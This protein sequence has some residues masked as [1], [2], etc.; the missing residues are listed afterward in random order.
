MRGV[1]LTS[2]PYP[3][4]RAG[5]GR[6]RALARP[7][8]LESQR[9]AG[10]NSLGEDETVLILCS[11]PPLCSY[12]HSTPAKTPGSPK[13]WLELAGMSWGGSALGCGF[14]LTR[15]GSRVQILFYGGCSTS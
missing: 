1:A 12:F 9:M 15:R 13:P 5:H 3:P 4:V 8:L 11:T 7:L 14:R 2:D 6:G 10:P